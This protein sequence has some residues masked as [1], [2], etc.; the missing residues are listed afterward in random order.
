[1]QL[2]DG[3]IIGNRRYRHY[4]KVYY[5]PMNESE[6]RMKA[7]LGPE[8]YADRQTAL[9]KYEFNEVTPCRAAVKIDRKNFFKTFSLLSLPLSHTHINVARPPS[10]SP[11]LLVAVPKAMSISNLGES[12]HHL[13]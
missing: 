12:F 5:R 6:G 11:P 7:I 4:Y 10:P 9:A 1:M 3:K 2:P 13:R 8:S